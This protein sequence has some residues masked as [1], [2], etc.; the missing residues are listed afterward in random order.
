MG[1]FEEGSG[2]KATGRMFLGQDVFGFESQD[3]F[4]SDPPERKS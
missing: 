4:E 3:P 1:R 2:L